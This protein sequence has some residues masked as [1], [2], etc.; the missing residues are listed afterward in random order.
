MNLGIDRSKT[1]DILVRDKEAWLFCAESMED[2][3]IR[4]LTRVRH[5]AVRCE[6]VKPDGRH[7]SLPYGNDFRYGFLRSSGQCDCPGFSCFQ[8][9]NLQSDSGRLCVCERQ[10]CHLK[11]PSAEGRGSGIC[12]GNGKVPLH[13]RPFGVPQRPAVC[14]KLKN[15]CNKYGKGSGIMKEG[16][17]AVECV[18]GKKRFQDRLYDLS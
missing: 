1:G 17:G 7:G 10:T 18:A 16:K 2:F 5:T 13:R 15:M 8:E 9:Q 3:I 12:P 11:R 4:E 14:G 6:S